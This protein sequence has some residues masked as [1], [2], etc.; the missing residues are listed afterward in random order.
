MECGFPTEQALGELAHD[1]AHGPLGE[2]ADGL[3]SAAKSGRSLAKAAERFPDV[4]DAMS[5]DL[6]TYGEARDLPN[7][8]RAI[9]QLI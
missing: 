4:F 9:T 7:A 5:L 3:R 1:F 6:M 2:V 8:L